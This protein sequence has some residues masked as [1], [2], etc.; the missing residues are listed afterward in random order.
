VK[1]SSKTTRDRNTPDLLEELR[2]HIEYQQ[3]NV[4]L[5]QFVGTL[6]VYPEDRREEPTTTS[7]GLDNILLRGCRLKDTDYIYGDSHI[8]FLLIFHDLISIFRIH[9]GCAVYTG[10]DTKLGLN[11]LLTGIKFSTVEK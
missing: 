10:Q 11:S 2:A 4:N 5:Y 9:T 7:L 8:L 6:T 1:H 3:P